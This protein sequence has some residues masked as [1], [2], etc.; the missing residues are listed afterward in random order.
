MHPLTS[1][2][3][4]AAMLLGAAAESC[5]RS[6]RASSGGAGAGAGAG[7][8]GQ[9]EWHGSD[10]NL[11]VTLTLRVVGDSISGEGTYTV[12]DPGRLGC[13]GETIAKSGKASLAGLRAGAQFGGRF[14]LGEGDGAWTPPYS[15]AWIPPDSLRGG[16]MS[17]DRGQCPLILVR[18]Q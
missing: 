13:G 2:L 17:V 4:A 15:G 18:R 14:R 6:P 8:A 7:A 9:S 11:D 16:F 5:S 10:G 12:R 1:S 3:L